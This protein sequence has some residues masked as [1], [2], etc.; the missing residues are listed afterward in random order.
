MKKKWKNSLSIKMQISL[1]SIK[2]C[3]CWGNLGLSV[4]LTPI[5]PNYWVEGHVNII[6]VS[7][8][9]VKVCSLEQTDPLFKPFT[10]TYLHCIHGHRNDVMYSKKNVKSSV[11]ILD[12]ILVLM[13]ATRKEFYIIFFSSFHSSRLCH[14]E[15]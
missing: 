8:L 4:S 3:H 10:K 1:K 2:F 11:Y 14:I 15:M 9:S 6:S 7:G 12:L 5:Y 13:V